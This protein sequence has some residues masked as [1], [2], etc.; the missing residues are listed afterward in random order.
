MSSE[1]MQLF[2]CL[3]MSMLRYCTD[4]GSVS[5]VNMGIMSAVRCN[6][7]TTARLSRLQLCDFELSVDFTEPQFP[8]LRN[9]LDGINNSLGNL[10]PMAQ[11]L[12]RASA[13]KWFLEIFLGRI[14]QL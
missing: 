7:R 13:C 11:S 8:L 12:A 6:G 1:L 5:I 10:A 3:V 4:L 14:P 9:K 2:A